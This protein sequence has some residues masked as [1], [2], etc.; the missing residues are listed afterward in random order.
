MHKSPGNGSNNK[1]WLSSDIIK[2]IRP[3]KCKTEVFKPGIISLENRNEGNLSYSSKFNTFIYRVF[4]PELKDPLKL[5]TYSK[6]GSAEITNQNISIDSEFREWDFNFDRTG[7]QFYFTSDRPLEAH[8]S[9]SNANSKIWKVAYIN[10]IWGEPFPLPPPVNISN[11]FSGY[12]AFT[13]NSLMYFHSN[14]SE[15]LGG[16]DIYTCISENN[17]FTQLSHPAYPI[18]TR[19]N[20][21][22]PAIS[23]DG[24]VLIFFSDRPGGSYADGDLYICSRNMKGEWNKAMP[25]GGLIGYAGHPY[26]SDDGNSLFF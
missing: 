6:R 10:G 8:I 3:G 23:P 13:D 4:D 2:P 9:E 19:F 22:D 14:R 21:R 24:S 25:L 18:N 1:Y 7:K 5:I 20:D 26:I 17:S 11:S 12:P 15:S 16:D